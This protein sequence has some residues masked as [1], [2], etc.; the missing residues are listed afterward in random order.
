MAF[1]SGRALGEY[2]GDEADSL[3]ETYREI[4][5]GGGQGGVKE[6]DTKPIPGHP[7]TEQTYRG[8]KWIRTK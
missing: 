2:Y 7:G 3:I 5:K 4:A 1:E 6:G 8:G